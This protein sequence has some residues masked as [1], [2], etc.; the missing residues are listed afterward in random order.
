M[1]ST[2][3]RLLAWWRESIQ[4]IRHGKWWL[5]IL[6]LGSW[7]L[8]GTLEHR[9]FGW[10]NNF[11]DA[12]GQDVAVRAVRLLTIGPSVKFPLI[13]FTTLVAFFVV[14]AYVKTKPG[15]VG[16][17]DLM[18]QELEITDLEIIGDGYTI[19]LAAFARMEVA[20]LDKPRTVTRFEIEMVAPDGTRYQANSE[21]QLGNYHYK[22]DV[23]KL[24]EW[25][26]SSSLG[27]REPM[28]DLAAKLRIPI[29]P[30]THVG[31]AWVRFELSKVKQGHEPKNCRITLFAIDPSGKRHENR[32]RQ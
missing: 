29:Q 23:K 19:N 25:G 11:V 20:S 21:Y 9:F 30:F 26:G 10:L 2:K 24:N 17:A 7:L 12:H 5:V 32:D 6:P 15:L 8:I 4:D 16:T 22:H 1:E 28:E 14:R 18:V 3:Q 13:I 31:R 27:L